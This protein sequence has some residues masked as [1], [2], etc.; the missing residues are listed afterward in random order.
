MATIIVEDAIPAIIDKKTFDIVQ[1]KLRGRTHSYVRKEGYLLASLIRCGH[2]GRNLIGERKNPSRPRKYLCRSRSQ[3]L[4]DCHAYQI[5][6]KLIESYLVGIAQNCLSEKS[7][8]TLRKKLIEKRKARQGNKSNRGASVKRRLS[9]LEAKIKRGAETMLV[10]SRADL[11]DLSETLAEWRN[12][13]DALKS[14]LSEIEGSDETKVSVDDAIAEL[15]NLRKAM[16]GASKSK[17]REI[18]Q[19]IFSHVEIFWEPRRLDTKTDFGMFKLA[20]GLAVFWNGIYAKPMEFG[21][22]ELGCLDSAERVA[23]GVY[24]ALDGTMPVTTQEVT[25]FLGRSSLWS[26]QSKLVLAEER[27][28]IGSCEIDIP[29]GKRTARAWFPTNDSLFA[30]YD[31]S[32]GV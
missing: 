20:R 29:L 1:K 5:D 32:K 12:Q 11:A 2:C 10:A 13:R 19:R 3:Q 28:L 25:A 21:R 24:G 27:G 17:L 31:A 6:A 23:V 30:R 15:R 7:V 4:S 18:L 8:Q 16:K 26:V 9:A 14:Q 22:P